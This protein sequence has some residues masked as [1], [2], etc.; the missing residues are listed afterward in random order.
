MKRDSF[1]R[2]A[3]LLACIALA[4]TAVAAPAAGDR[5][6][7]ATTAREAWAALAGPKA[8]PKVFSFVENDPALPNILIYGDSISMGYTPRVRE[9]LAGKANIYRLHI[10]GSDSGRVIERTTLLEKT[11]R[12]PKLEGHWDFGW[13]VI[14]FNV[15]L[16]DLKYMAGSKLD[17]VN[18]KQ[19]R[20]T[21]DY[22]DNIRKI[23]AY[24]K[25]SAP[26]ATLIFITTTPVPENSAGRKAGSELAYN[27]AA[28]DALKAFPEVRILD[29]HAFSK[30]HE[31]EW[32]K[33]PGNVH[34]NAAG[35]KGQGDEVARVIEETLAARK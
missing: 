18:G 30:P 13:D 27:A 8:D 16:H 17:S 25:Q 34:Y 1:S 7:T 28:L 19:V 29:L 35:T 9:A 6:T 20:S 33:G 31:A 12:D 15:G 23:V 5:A 24:F 26:G 4:A 21:A 10:N 14:L 22:A 32:L 2:A 11:M 3:I